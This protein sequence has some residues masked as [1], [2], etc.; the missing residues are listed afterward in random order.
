M[1]RQYF[2]SILFIVI[3]GLF[4]SAVFAVDYGQYRS[5][6]SDVKAS[7]VGELITVF[8]VESVTAE[9]SA[10]TGV[11]RTTQLDASAFDTANSVGVGL[12][13][14][15]TGR[16]AG[17]TARSGRVRTQLS[18][19]ITELL[20]HG[21]Y[22]IEGEHT[23]ILNGEKQTI[24]LA[25]TIRAKDVTKENSLSSYQIANATIEIIGKGDLT[26]AQKQNYFTRILQA[27]GIM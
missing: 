14:D 20:P 15:A 16:G 22:R 18:T 5:L 11:E 13:I 27:L 26:D 2:N 24:K 3:G 12:N 1:F 9:S 17:K 21:M 6:T 23:L 4:S 7:R 19:V 10:A 25:G 8:V